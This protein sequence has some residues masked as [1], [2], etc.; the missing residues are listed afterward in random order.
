MFLTHFPGNRHP[1]FFLLLRTFVLGLKIWSED[2]P[3]WFLFFFVEPPSG[4]ESLLPP[5]VSLLY[6]LVRSYS[7][8]CVRNC[9]QD[10]PF[11]PEI[12]T[13]KEK[14]CSPIVQVG[15]TSV[16]CIYTV[17]ILAWRYLPLFTAQ[18]PSFTSPPA[19]T[20]L[21][22]PIW[23]SRWSTFDF[24]GGDIPWVSGY[25]ERCSTYND[26]RFT[27]TYWLKPACGK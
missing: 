20:C 10:S 5:E 6:P 18:L 25:P 17:A 2:R 19:F 3:C 23:L 15:I 14:F 27:S 13:A 11:V 4:E 24:L 21:K 26:F 1:H 16:G 7:R 9:L 22:A 8:P 12:C